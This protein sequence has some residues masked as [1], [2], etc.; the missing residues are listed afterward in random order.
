M[1][2]L[3]AICGQG[4]GTVRKLRKGHQ[5]HFSKV[6]IFSTSVKM[7]L[8]RVHQ[9]STTDITRGRGKIKDLASR[10]QISSCSLTCPYKLKGIAINMQN[11]L[12]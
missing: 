1:K 10:Q 2:I 4:E 6:F 7:L 5:K 9:P 12:S 8:P 3:K 11:G